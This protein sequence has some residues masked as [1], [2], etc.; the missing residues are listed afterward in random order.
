MVYFHE[1]SGIFFKTIINFFIRLSSSLKWFTV[2]E[3][4]DRWHK[5]NYKGK[6]SAYL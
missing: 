1:T 4:C 3:Q 2:C 6:F 5:Q